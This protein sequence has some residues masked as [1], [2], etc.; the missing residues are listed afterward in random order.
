MG[1]YD[2]LA[3]L[4]LD[5]DGYEL[6]RHERDTS[7]DFTR[8]S[9][10]FELHGNGH[11]GR[12]EDV[13]YDTPDHDALLEAHDFDFAGTYTHETF[14]AFLDDISLFAQPPER[15]TAHHYRRWA[16]E[17]AALDLAL[18]Q[19]GTSLGAALGRSYDPVRFIVSTRLGDP[20]TF[21]RI[22]AIQRVFPDA[23]FKLDPTPDWDDG[24]V[25][26]LAETGAVRVLDLKGLYEGTSVDQAPDP[27]LYRRVVE[28]FPDSVIED[29]GLTDD[30]RHIF[31]DHEARVSWDYPITGIES[32]ESL[33]FEPQWLNIKPS[34]FGT[35][36]S[37]L[38]TI[39]Y[40]FERDIT[41]YGGGQFELAV[42]RDHIQALASLFYPDAP[43]DVA[44][45]GYND[46]EL[47]AGLPTSP[48]PAPVEP[49]GLDWA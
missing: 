30:T 12:G 25:A 42:G 38:D 37:L 31:D 15:D 39:D 28:G 23:E 18:K 24:L 48:L 26:S 3:D 8:V 34:R 1:L 4:P 45:G 9:T 32:I 46:P 14:S 27:D 6:T 10:V 17:S 43:N 41:M 16:V 7:S 47:D 2:A 35:V 13:T 11:V 22:D 19:A 20:P 40:C 21:D 36:E 44:P 49:N 33:P 5:I 29:P